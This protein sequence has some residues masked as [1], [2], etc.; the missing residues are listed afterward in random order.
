MLPGEIS[1]HVENHSFSSFDMS[2]FFEDLART[3]TQSIC[4]DIDVPFIVFK[5]CVRR[6]DAFIVI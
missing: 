6:I 3:Y 2:F 4:V 5:H 1:I